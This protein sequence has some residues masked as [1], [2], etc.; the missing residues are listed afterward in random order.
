LCGCTYRWLD[1]LPTFRSSEKSEEK[2]RKKSCTFANQYGKKQLY[3]KIPKF[4]IAFCPCFWLYLPPFSGWLQLRGA[5]SDIRYFIAEFCVGGHQKAALR[6]AGCVVDA[7]SDSGEFGLLSAVEILPCERYGGGGCSGGHTL[8]GGCLG[9]GHR[10]P[11]GC[12]P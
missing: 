9:G 6:L 8:P 12:Q 3:V 10:L 7:L 4:S 2:S 1:L 5:V 11:I